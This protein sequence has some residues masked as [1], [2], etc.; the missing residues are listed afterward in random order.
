M[1]EYE[2]FLEELRELQR[3]RMGEGLDIPLPDSS[4]KD[5]VGDAAAG[6]GSNTIKSGTHA[7]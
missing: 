3:E 4:M 6:G 7:K 2:D 1:Q 5:A